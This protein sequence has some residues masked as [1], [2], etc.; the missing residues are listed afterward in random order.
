MTIVRD[1]IRALG[2]QHTKKLAW[3]AGALCRER[4]A[5]VTGDKPEFELAVKSFGNGSHRMADYPA[6]FVPEIDRIVNALGTQRDMQMTIFDL[7]QPDE[8]DG[9]DLI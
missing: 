9:D 5:E 4:F 6:W 2:F 8:D 7:L 1:R 3:S